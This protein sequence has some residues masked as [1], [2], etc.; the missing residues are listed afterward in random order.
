MAH[1]AFKDLT[2][3]LFQRCVEKVDFQAG[4]AMQAYLRSGV[5]DAK[6]IVEWA[7]RAKKTVSVR[8][9]KGAYWDAETIKSEMHG[10]PCPVWAEK[11]QTDACF[12]R[13]TEVFL[14]ACPR[15]KGEPG[16]KLA[17]GSQNVRSIAAALAGLEARGLPQAAIELQMLHGMADQLKFAA[18]EL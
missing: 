3:E 1:H 8:L 2:I 16:G 6:R 7:R 11:W 12:E 14:D 10:W 13:M 17:L 15:V 18:A 9:V 5:E 4:L